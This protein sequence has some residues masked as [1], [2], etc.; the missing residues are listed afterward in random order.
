VCLGYVIGLLLVFG[1]SLYLL[2]GDAGVGK[3]LYDAGLPLAKTD[4]ED[5]PD[6]AAPDA[7][8]TPRP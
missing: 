8:R 7:A 1:L 6:F 2:P 4:A 3:L 5:S